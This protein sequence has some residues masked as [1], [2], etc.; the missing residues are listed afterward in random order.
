MAQEL[1]VV[2]GAGQVGT[3]LAALLLD[4]GKRVRVVRRSS[5]AVTPGVELLTGDAAVP[6]WVIKAVGLFVPLMREVAE[7]LYQW[8][9]VFVVD[10]GRFRSQ[11]ETP[12]T[13]ARDAARATVAWAIRAYGPPRV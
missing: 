7:M 4:A 10:D 12:P 13:D 9:E 11:F 5:G 8:E 2:F 1:H 3:P 6:P